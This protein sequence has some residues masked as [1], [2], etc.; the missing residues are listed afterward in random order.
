MKDVTLHLALPVSFLIAG[1]VLIF[2]II[3]IGLNTR[4]HKPKLKEQRTK[5]TYF[6]KLPD[7]NL[8]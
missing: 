1:I 6:A 5:V 2:F 8:N 7:W 4:R 3:R